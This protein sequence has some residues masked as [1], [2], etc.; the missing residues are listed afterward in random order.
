VVKI[1]NDLAVRDDLPQSLMSWRGFEL[2]DD[3]NCL[4]RPLV[5]EASL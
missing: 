3:V 5:T 4:G 2:N 1:V